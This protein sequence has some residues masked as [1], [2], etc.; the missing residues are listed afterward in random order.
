[1]VPLP[2]QKAPSGSSHRPPDIFDDFHFV[3]LGIRGIREYRPRSDSSV[4]FIPGQGVSVWTTNALIG[5]RP[6][7]SLPTDEIGFHLPE[8]V[9]P[10]GYLG[11]NSRWAPTP[12]GH[13]RWPQ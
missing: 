3:T 8:T 1:M 4:A 9:V 12:S 7:G 11:G 10:K 5:T 6:P 13:G 2:F